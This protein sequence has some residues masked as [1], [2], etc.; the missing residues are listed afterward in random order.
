[1]AAVLATWFTAPYYGRVA[2]ANLHPR[3]FVSPRVTLHHDALT[4]GRHC[5]VG[6]G[7]LIYQDLRGGPV[8]L[9]N[10]VHLHRDGI[11]QTGEGGT[12]VIGD[13]THIQPRCQISAYQGSVRIGKRVEVGPSCAFYPYNHALDPGVPIRRQPLRSKSGIVIG[14]DVWLG[15]GVILLDGAEVGDGAV[16][17]AG[18]VVTGRV[19]ANAIAAGVPARVLRYRDESDAESRPPNEQSLTTKSN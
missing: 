18:S 8:S 9:G 4:V 17:G 16:I 6:E 13:E 7:V 2:L 10:G 14:D 11:L 1:M 12:I 3:G 15:Y 19:P 5:F